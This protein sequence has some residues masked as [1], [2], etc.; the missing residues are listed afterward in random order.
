MPVRCQWN[1]WSSGF[2]HIASLEGRLYLQKQNALECVK[3]ILSLPCQRHKGTFLQQSLWEPARTLA[4]G[5]HESVSGS[6]VT[7]SPRG[8][9]YPT[10]PPAGLQSQ[11]GFLYRGAGFRGVSSPVSCDCFPLYLPVTLFSFGDC[12]LLY[13]FS[14]GSKKLLV[15][16][17]FGVYLLLRESGHS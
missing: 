5:A 2:S 8:F 15:F 6:V 14:C 3:T 9:K 13:D 4:G 17:L 10:E 12:R 16:T 11:I 1:L 7:G